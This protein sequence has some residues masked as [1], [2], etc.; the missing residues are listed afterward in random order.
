MTATL[1]SV[2]HL[3]V[4]RASPDGSRRA[5]TDASFDIEAG[6]ALAIVGESG[7]GKSS[8]GL[9]VL[10]LVPPPGAVRAD[11]LSLRGTDLLALD[12]NGLRPLRG[13]QMALVAQEPAG[14]LDPYE[15]IGAQLG[16]V[17]R[18]HEDLGRS[19]ARARARQALEAVGLPAVD[20]LLG[21]RPPTLSAGARDSVLIAMALIHRPGL[22]VL[23]E[24]AS[25]ADPLLRRRL[26]GIVDAHRRERGAGVLLLTS[27]SRLARAIDGEIAVIQQGFIVELGPAARVLDEPLHPYAQTLF[28]GRT[29]NPSDP[30]PSRRLLL[31]DAPDEKSEPSSSGCHHADA[32]PR[33]RR[34]PHQAPLCRGEV[35]ALRTL[36]RGR[37]VRCHLVEDD[38]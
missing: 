17:L 7:S 29:G 37:R 13:S 36:A 20:A 19:E 9:A 31:V 14:A 1:L 8:L 11:R 12:E 28:G 22:C 33:L 18:S 35:P 4:T 5:V 24:P 6:G 32:C 10:G 27:D 30:P 38:V 21:R 3:D 34:M 25:Q 23:D 2:R 16:D 15:T 26:L